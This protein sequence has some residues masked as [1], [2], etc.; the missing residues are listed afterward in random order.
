[1]QTYKM[2]IGGEWVE[3]ANGETFETFNPYTGE[4]W[5]NIPRGRAEDAD[6]AVQAASRAFEDGEWSRMN[7]TARGHIMR[8]L[9]DLITENAQHLA[10]IEVRDNGKLLS[11]M[12][13]QTRYV[14]QWF[15][16][17]GGL[18][19]K[20]QG[21]VI[22]I[23]KANTFNFT[24]HEPLGVCVAITAWNSP[25]LLA[26]YKLGPGLAAGNTFVLKPSEFTSASALEFGKLAEK[27]GLPPGVINIVTGF[28]AEV[29]EYRFRRCQ[30]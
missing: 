15:H 10:E 16:Y 4:A 26:A 23:D 9:G 11:E 18:A 5:A 1:M 24:R 14:P 28:G 17:F 25:L 21:A 20:L 2:L 8:R 29:G 30:A 19:D 13:G 22:P 6:R 7:A 12:L 3:A 27:A